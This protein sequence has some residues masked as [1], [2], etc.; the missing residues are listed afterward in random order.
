MDL[1]QHQLVCLRPDLVL[2]LHFGGTSAIWRNGTIGIARGGRACPAFA[3][4]AP[5]SRLNPRFRRN[6]RRGCPP[7]SP[8]PKAAARRPFCCKRPPA[9]KETDEQAVGAAHRET[10]GQEQDR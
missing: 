3:F 6:E 9:G 10:G 8:A 1:G 4:F 7:I 2:F 5:R